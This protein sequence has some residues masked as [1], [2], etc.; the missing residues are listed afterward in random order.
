MSMI[1]YLI[2]L[3]I[4]DHLRTNL[5]TGIATVSPLYVNTIEAF[6]YLKNPNS[7][8]TRVVVYG[9][10]PNKLEY[11]DGRIDMTSG[12]SNI[13]T[14]GIHIPAG[15]IGGGYLWWRRGIITLQFYGIGKYQQSTN[16]VAAEVAYDILG[17]VQNCLGSVQISN[18]VDQFGE[19]ALALYVYSSDF[20]ESGGNRTNIWEGDIYWQALTERVN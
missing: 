5:N 20:K 1:K 9:D 11:R 7:D 2:S 12:N 6:N 3:A 14:L 13:P 18:L 8:S 19:R 16:Y 4:R 10:N 15:E 17:R